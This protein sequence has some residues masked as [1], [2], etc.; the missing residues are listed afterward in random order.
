VGDAGPF[1]LVV[2]DD[3]TLGRVLARMVRPFGEAAV[4]GNVCAARHLLEAPVAW[5]AFVID[6]GLP[7]GS[8]L[9]V[10]VDART[11]FPRAPA[12]VL[13]GQNEG[14]DVDSAH[15]L[16]ADYVIKPVEEARLRRFLLA[17][18]SLAKQGGARADGPAAAPPSSRGRA[19]ETLGSRIADLRKLFA[20][21]PDARTRYAIGATLAEIKSRPEQYG[22]GSVAAVAAA[23]REDVP[24]L[25]R[26]AAVAERWTAAEVDEL[27]ERRGPNGKGLSWSHLVT[28]GAVPGAAARAGLVERALAEGLSVR[29]LNGLANPSTGRAMSVAR[30]GP[31]SRRAAHRRAGHDPLP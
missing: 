7:D 4:A 25:Y 28:L 9:D 30:G 1:F 5:T 6:V 21:R 8:G 15:Q 3:C 12:M 26:H 13:A 19:R 16:R 23:L 22:A 11:A 29:A 10:L 27:L 20:R 17:A 24:S 31:T 18:A 2:E 14:T